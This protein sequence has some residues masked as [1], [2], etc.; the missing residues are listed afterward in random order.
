MAYDPRDPEDKKIV[1]K[2]IDEA[3]AEQTT[4]HEEATEGLKNKNTELL[5]DLRKAKAAQPKGESDPAEVTRLEEQ[6]EENKKLLAE[7]NKALKKTQ[8]ELEEN[9]AA[10]GAESAFASELLINTNLSAALAEHKVAP[11]F[12]EATSA[13]LKSQVSIKNENGQRSVVAGDK[14]LGDFVKS[15]AES[16]KGKAFIAAPGNNGSGA[17]GGQGSGNNGGKQMTR[18]D[19]DTA[20][21]SGGVGLSKFFKEGGVLVDG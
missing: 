7:A 11:Q 13:F 18:S 5:R 3:L 21:K 2:L 10:L 16:D 8:K 9:T 1:Q 14:S 17:T 20:I 6:L 19:Y 15:W 12:L 4:E